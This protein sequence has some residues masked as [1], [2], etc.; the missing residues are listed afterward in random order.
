MARTPRRRASTATAGAP[1]NP[2]GDALRRPRENLPRAAAPAPATA[3]RPAPPRR[4]RSP[5][6]FLGRLEPRF[7]A[8]I[9][10]ELRKVT[11]PTFAETRYLTLV[12]A[13]VA[14]AVGI[15]LGAVDFVFGWVIEQLFF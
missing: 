15:F 11:W 10:S 7:V 13:I 1:A 9:I 3:P 6:A 8:D 4:R 5:F 2:A 12:V 14:V